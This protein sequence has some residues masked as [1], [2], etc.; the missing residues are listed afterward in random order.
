MAQTE[1]TYTK[2]TNVSKLKAEIEA[3]SIATPLHSVV[4]FDADDLR[5]VFDDALSVGDEATLTALVTAHDN[6]PTPTITTVTPIPLPTTKSV[7][8]GSYVRITAFIFEGTSVENAPHCV[9]VLC[10]VDVGAVGE[11]RVYDRTNGVVIGQ[12]TFSNIDE[13]LIDVSGLTGWSVDSSVIEFQV[14]RSVGAGNNEVNII[15][16]SVLS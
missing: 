16:L 10:S 4:V 6:S 14:R 11:V 3:S 7:K 9:R 15:A 2:P 8:T 5:V 12:Q 13:E 1:Y